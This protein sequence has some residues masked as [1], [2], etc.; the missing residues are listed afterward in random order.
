MRKALIVAAL[1]VVGCS[2]DGGQDMSAID[3][4]VIDLTAG[5]PDMKVPIVVNGTKLLD[6][7]LSLIGATSDDFVAA[8]DANGLLQVVSI[9]GGTPEP[10]ASMTGDAR[11]TGKTVFAWNNLD[12]AT[13][14]AE[15][16]MWTNA[17]KVQTLGATATD[18]TAAALPDGSYVMFTDGADANGDVA[19]IYVAKSDGSGKVKV[20]SQRLAFRPCQP[21]IGVAGQKFVVA[22]CASAGDAG[23]TPA[24]ISLVDPT[25]G[26]VTTVASNAKPFVSVSKPGT[27]VLTLEDTTSKLSVVTIGGATQLIE[28]T[29]VIQAFFNNAGTEVTYVT[30]AGAIKRATIGGVAIGTIGGAGVKG[31]DDVSPDE[32]FL[33]YHKVQDTSGVGDLYF[34]ST[35]PPGTP[36]TIAAGGVALFGDN[37]TTDSKFLLYYS[38]LDADLAGT[39]NLQPL[40]GGAVIKLS[41]NRVWLSYTTAGSK[42]VFNDNWKNIMM[43]G[44]ADLQVAGTGG[45]M[46]NLISVQ[47]D[48]SIGL[49]AGKTK[50]LYTYRVDTSKAGLYVAP[51]D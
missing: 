35:T 2:D 33:I 42:V 39:L 41:T 16:K 8:A 20:L 40:P 27:H 51:A 36:F 25:N 10:V 26:N 21:R 4:S 19:D 3:M 47:A 44:R 34:A 32:K 6:G 5:G 14:V 30:M 15:L 49:N 9:A 13:G 43:L 28:G 12:Q 18:G 24:T 1:F 31:I 22:H 50:V 48:D 38:D 29:A 45:G 23:A 46:P 11:V 17:N 37:F 7:K